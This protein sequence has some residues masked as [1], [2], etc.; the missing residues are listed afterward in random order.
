MQ[1]FGISFSRLL[2]DCDNVL[3]TSLQAIPQLGAISVRGLIP[4]MVSRRHDEMNRTTFYF[5]KY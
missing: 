3:F 1:L 5:T 2:A 4:K